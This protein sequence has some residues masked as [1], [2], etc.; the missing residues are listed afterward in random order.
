MDGIFSAWDISWAKSHGKT[1]PARLQGSHR[2]AL[3]LGA[4]DGRSEG[5]IGGI[6]HPWVLI[7]GVLNMIYM[8]Y[9]V[10]QY[11]SMVFLSWVLVWC[12]NEFFSIGI[13]FNGA[14]D[15]WISISYVS[16]SVSMFTSI[17]VDG[18]RNENPIPCFRPI[19][20]DESIWSQWNGPN[21]SRRNYPINPICRENMKHHFHIN[22]RMVFQPSKQWDVC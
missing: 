5:G 1:P 22:F 11:V 21:S 14:D 12:L 16:V 19:V 6:S 8:I 18:W 3:G 13:C 9:M 17:V 15:V 7:Y 4:Q 10:F 2:R 20:G